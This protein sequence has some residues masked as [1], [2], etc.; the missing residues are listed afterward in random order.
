MEGL[1][2]QCLSFIVPLYK[3]NCKFPSVNKNSERKLFG[4]RCVRIK[5]TRRSARYIYIRRVKE[6]EI[7][8]DTEVCNSFF[9]SIPIIL[10]K[11]EIQSH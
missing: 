5:A 6:D 1:T 4:S 11:R 7:A 3:G 2:K 8:S 10:L 9:L